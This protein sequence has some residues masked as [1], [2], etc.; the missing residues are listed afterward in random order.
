MQKIFRFNI[1]T[2]YFLLLFYGLLIIVILVFL[3]AYNPI[4]Y[5]FIIGVLLALASFTKQ[6]II[7]VSNNEFKLEERSLV[8]IFNKSYIINLNDIKEII[9][10]HNKSNFLDILF[11]YIPI[12]EV[13]FIIVFKD[14]KV[15]EIRNN[16]MSKSTLLEIKKTL[17]GLKKF[18]VTFK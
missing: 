14:N 2:F 3:F 10:I 9:L 4:L 18:K 13:K 16:Y 7:I 1:L 5:S 6:K 15:L 8:P 12:D 17:Y 11:G